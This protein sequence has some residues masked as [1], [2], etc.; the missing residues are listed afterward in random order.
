MLLGVALAMS[1]FDAPVPPNIRKQ[2]SSGKMIGLVEKTVLLLKAKE[3]QKTNNDFFTNLRY[4]FSLRKSTRTK[5]KVLYHHIVQLFSPTIFDI[6]DQKNADK[7]YWWLVL[8]KPFRIWRMHV[9][10]KQD[11]NR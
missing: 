5:L 2:A 3:Q 1:T 9:R 6:L 11:T 4:Q 10:S 8:S 7:R